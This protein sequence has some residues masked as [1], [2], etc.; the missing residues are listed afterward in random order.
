MTSLQAAPVDIALPLLPHF[1][2]PGADGHITRVVPNSSQK[3]GKQNSFKTETTFFQFLSY[4]WYLTNLTILILSKTFWSHQEVATRV[5]HRLRLIIVV[6]SF[7]SFGLRCHPDRHGVS[8]N[9]WQMEGPLIQ[10]VVTCRT[11]NQKRSKKC[12]VFRCRTNFQFE[13]FWINNNQHNDD[14]SRFF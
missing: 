9:C 12:S 1:A 8:P 11:I 14:N 2:D 3:I 5:P 7:A 4:G 13:L 6:L 10:K